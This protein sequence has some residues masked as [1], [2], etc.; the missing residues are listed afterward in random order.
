MTEATTAPSRV[1]VL[2][3]PV[4]RVD[5]ASAIAWVTARMGR[6]G[7]PSTVLAV[8]PEKVFAIRKDPFLA[9]FFEDAAVLLPDGIGVVLA[10]RALHGRGA[11]RV[12][13]VE[14]MDALCAEAAGNGW[15]I[16]LYGAQADVNRRAA[17]AL[18]ER[19]QGIRIVGRSDGY[20]PE[21]GMETLVADINASGAQLLF[22]AL[23]SPRQERWM[24]RHLP[25]LQV[26]VVQGVG[27]S[28]DVIT[29]DVPRAPAA[30]RRVGLE[31]FYRLLKQPSRWRRQIVYPVFAVFVAGEWL[32]DRVRSLRRR[33]RGQGAGR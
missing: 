9:R 13:G 6:D 20:V 11:T 26:K 21:E 4:D 7:P 23:G 16:Y 18:A 31:W 14:L 27:G 8:N 24:D 10:T 28:L 29:G 2:G 19:H 17:A 15:G 1:R 5:M 32:R 33:L 3:V 22:V 25:A 30:F 12:P